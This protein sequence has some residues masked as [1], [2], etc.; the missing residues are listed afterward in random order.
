[1]NFL[2]LLLAGQSIEA[3]PVAMPSRIG[4]QV[5]VESHACIVRNELGEKA[6]FQLDIDSRW[7]FYRYLNDGKPRTVMGSYLKLFG[8][9]D[10]AGW[11]YEENNKYNVLGFAFRNLT[12]GKL[13]F[14]FGVFVPPG[15]EVLYSN[16]APKYSLSSLKRAITVIVIE[17]GKSATLYAGVCTLEKSEKMT[18]Q[19]GVRDFEQ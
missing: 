9:G 3:P 12:G 1:V 8:N 15:V 4:Q 2:A 7:T 6:R 5:S 16:T 18:A 10:F 11:K 13:I 14:Q 19:E 17:D